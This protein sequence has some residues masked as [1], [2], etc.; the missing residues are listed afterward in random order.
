MKVGGSVITEKSGEA[1][2]K[3]EVMESAA[4]E[5]SKVDGRLILI[6]GAGSF[7]HPIAEKY[8]LHSGYLGRW[9]LK[10][11]SELKVNLMELSRLFL[12]ALTR[13][14]VSAYPFMPSSFVTSK[15]GRIFYCALKPL[16]RVLGLGAAP[17]LHGDLVPD[18]DSGFSITSGDQ[19][20]SF[21][22]V[23][24]KPRMVIFGCDVD[25]LYTRDPKRHS[26]A[27]LIR[28][29][30][31]GDVEEKLKS[32]ESTDGVDVTGGIYGK[33]REAALIAGVG[34]PTAI[35]NMER[36]GRLL[37]LTEEGSVEGTL[38]TPNENRG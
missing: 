28:L 13:S 20:A 26:D 14:G 10:G 1:V 30:K 6:H 27:K 15:N 31:V 9:Q 21:L 36:R 24:L 23:K 19:L 18:L 37:Q 11:V 25:G 5:I 34:V 16:R 8:K 7:G 22:A 32:V 33:I 2:P 4:E 17:L 3:L 38:I 29:L 35:V 12:S